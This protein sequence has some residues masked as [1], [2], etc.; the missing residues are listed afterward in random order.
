MTG[1]R[2]THTNTHMRLFALYRDYTEPML[3]FKTNER[4]KQM[5]I[6]KY[7]QKRPACSHAAGYMRTTSMLP[8]KD[9]VNRL[10]DCTPVGQG[11]VQRQTFVTIVKNSMK[12][13]RYVR[14]SASQ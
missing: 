7:K 14:L 6:R 5:L 8:Y 13:A 3:T 10:Q 2:N 4:C 11:K 9:P 12:F 1:A